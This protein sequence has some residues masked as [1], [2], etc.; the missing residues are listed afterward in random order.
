MISK[1]ITNSII[2]LLILFSACTKTEKVNEN[3]VVI[4]SIDGF[5]YDYPIKY[6][7]P[8]LDLIAKEGVKA[9]SMIPSYPSKT[10]PNHYA[11]ATGMYP[12]NNGL[13]HNSFYDPERKEMYRIGIG[14]KDGSWFYGTPLWTLAELQGVKAASFYWPVSDSRVQGITPSY[15]FKYNKSTPYAQRIDQIGNWL[16]IKGEKRPRFITLYFSLVDTQGHRYGPDANET[17]EAVEYIDQQIGALYKTIKASEHPV[18][19]IVVSD[20]GMENVDVEH[21]IILEGLGSFDNF[22]CVNGGGVQY[23]L[24]PNDEA[25]VQEVYAKLKAQ[26]NKGMHVYLKENIPANLHYSKGKRIPAIVC[27]A[28]PP[29][30]FK[31]ARGGVSKGTHGY[32]PYT[33]KNMHAIFYGVG[34]NFKKGVEIPSFEN[35][36]IYPA[37]AKIIGLEIPNDIDGKIEVLGP[38]LQ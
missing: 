3:T 18:N 10:F 11:I 9:T 34:P 27:E 25:N 17:K 14:K 1:N 38:Y 2:L 6:N 28:I 12:S 8:N 23:L 33:I 20:H 29:R 24:Y 19:L 15:Y 4:V 36:N 13:V 7:T 31:N 5:R 22:T 37:I 16:K 32:N 26:E 30:A 35:V 21:P